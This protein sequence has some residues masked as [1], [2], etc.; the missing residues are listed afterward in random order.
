MPNQTV[1]TSG[2][3]DLSLGRV[4]PRDRIL[5]A[6]EAER[7]KIEELFEVSGNTA[8]KTDLLKYGE[9]NWDQRQ[10]LPVP[11][12]Q[13][14]AIAQRLFKSS[15]AERGER[16]VIEATSEVFGILEELVGICEK[17]GIEI[18]FD[19][20]NHAREAV[21]AKHLSD[22][23]PEGGVSA[24]QTL[25][26]TRV[27]LYENVTKT[28]RV[29]TNPDPSIQEFI[30]SA[31]SNQL[32][33]YIAPRTQRLRSGDL[34]Y[35]LTYLPTVQDAALDGMEHSQYLNLFLEA[36]EQPW[37]A[38]NEAQEILKNKFD[39]AD[40]IRITNN[41]GTEITLDITGQTFANSVVL[42]NL[43]G[44]EI[45]SAPLRQGVNGR[46][47]AE[48]RFQ[49]RSS[50]IIEDITFEF[51]DGRIVSYDA[52]IGKE[53]LGEIIEMDK[54]EG[55]GSFYL[56]EIGIGTNPHLR[57]HMI[58]GLLVEKI[59]GSFHVAVG[60]CYSYTTYDG[61][62]VALQNGNQSKAGI[63]WDITTILRGKQGTMELIYDNSGSGEKT[64]L[65]QAD[66]EWL[67]SGCE[68]LNQGWGSQPVEMQPAWWRTGYPDGYG[69]PA[70]AN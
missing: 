70:K 12:E 9:A 25:A 67:V 68:V 16:I 6:E 35:I 23:A 51:K 3:A 48:G 50:G 54:G 22:N 57:R 27:E 41:D 8:L 17:E 26:N 13:A 56:G 32:E 58:N 61:R 15:R 18:L 59:G 45:F 64:E 31:K 34:H 43:P 39:R 53:V 1:D 33:N 38:I 40:K 4:S 55:D 30:D 21:F 63:H 69:S 49:F 62:P 52:R 5:F 42:K 36:C 37:E 7:L 19:F 46:I 47:A 10:P 11:P 65:V 44:S 29:L 2:A 66:G 24:L 20:R 14:A 60:S 28:I